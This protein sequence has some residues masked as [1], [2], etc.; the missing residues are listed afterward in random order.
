MSLNR[1]P[2]PTHPMTRKPLNSVAA[3]LSLAGFIAVLSA[4][5]GTALGI[6]F[7]LWCLGLLVWGF[8]YGQKQLRAA[9]ADR[10]LAR[11]AHAASMADRML[12]A[13]RHGH[14]FEASCAEWAEG[15]G[16]VPQ[17]VPERLAEEQR[18]RARHAADLVAEGVLR[19]RVDGRPVTVFDL[20][21]INESDVWEL[22]RR[23]RYS[24]AAEVSMYYLTV[25][26]VTLP[27]RLPYLASAYLHRTEAD[28]TDRTADPAFAELLLSRPAVRAAAQDRDWL[29]SVDGDRL[30]CCAV[31]G[32]GMDIGQ[33]EGLAGRMAAIAGAFPW[34]ELE[35]FRVPAP[36]S[37]PRHILWINTPDLLVDRDAPFGGLVQSWAEREIDRTGLYA[38]KARSEWLQRTSAALRPSV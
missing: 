21:V 32:R 29:W 19:M 28:D 11:K 35:H 10:A 14:E 6:T 2:L 15:F 5:G 38:L 9:E 22:K 13:Q 3:A 36:D 26:V 33:V 8:R 24:R 16:R 27:V 37:R 25:C 17:E 1:T 31:T 7:L 4:F 20:E 30:I 34:P 18:V 23:C 12:W